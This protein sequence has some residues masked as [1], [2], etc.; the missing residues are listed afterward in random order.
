MALYARF[1]AY[2]DLS[3]LQA[4]RAVIS[5]FLLEQRTASDQRTA[6]EIL[7]AQ[8]DVARL[9]REDRDPRGVDGAGEPGAGHHLVRGL[10]RRL[11]RRRRCP[12]PSFRW[13]ME[14]PPPRARASMLDR[15]GR[16]AES[17]DAH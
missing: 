14:M 16:R 8:L 12:W 7:A 5:E 10:R 2:Y 1:P 15:A 3:E 17:L 9:L 13:W 4:D 6:Y 11:G